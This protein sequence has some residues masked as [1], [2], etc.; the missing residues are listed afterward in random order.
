MTK[1]SLILRYT[2]VRKVRIAQI[3]GNIVALRSLSQNPGG[4]YLS[5][6]CFATIQ[7]K[8]ALT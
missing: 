8:V 2:I 1:I 7:R 4:H 3:N 5:Q 6:M